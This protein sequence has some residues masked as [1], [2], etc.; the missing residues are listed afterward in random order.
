MVNT[1]EIKHLALDV[2][3]QGVATLRIAN[4]TSLNIL[5]SDTIVEFTQTLRRLARRPDVRV[6]VLRGTGEK[7]FVGGANIKELARLDPET[8]VAFITRLHDLCEAVRDFP[9]PT[10]ARL[11]GWCMGC[12]LYT[13]DAADE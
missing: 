10:I 13:S 12:L 2:S 8:A 3:E 9:V 1:E 4:G 5:D 7:A 6:L 11:S